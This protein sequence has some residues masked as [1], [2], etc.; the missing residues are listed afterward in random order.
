MNISKLRDKLSSQYDSISD[1]QSI[2]EELE[3]SYQQLIAMSEQVDQTEEK[4]ALLIQ[5]MSDIVWIGNREGKITY[6]NEIVSDVLGYAREEMIGQELHRFMCPLHQYDTGDCKDLIESMLERDFKR[7]VLWM[8]HKDGKRRIILETNT[9]RVY[10]DGILME[11]QGVGRDVTERIQTERRIRRKNN[12]FEVLNHISSAIT[13]NL[14]LNNLDKL[15]DDICNN[16][17]VETKIPLCSIRLIDENGD[18]GV[19]AMGAGA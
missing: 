18:L 16:V 9:K 3:A 17:V 2:F 7:E 4:Y 11:I 10:F 12:Q 13:T 15:L 5:N 14:S 1:L 8:L 19:K 6:I